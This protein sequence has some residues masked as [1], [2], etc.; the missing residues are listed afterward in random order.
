MRARPPLSA[1]LQ[2]PVLQS[3]RRAATLLTASA[4]VPCTAAAQTARQPIAFAHHTTWGEAAGLPLSGVIKLA[5]TPDGYLWLGSTAGLLR[6][7]GMRFSVLDGRSVAALSSAVPGQTWPLLVDREGVLWISRPD[8]GIVQYRAGVFRVALDPDT[9][10]QRVFRMAQDGRGGL[11]LAGGGSLYTWADGHLARPRLPAAVPDTGILGVVPDTGSG[12]W[13]GTR[14][15]GLW[16]V[17]GEQARYYPTPAQTRDPGVRPLLQSRDGA[18]WVWGDRLQVLHRERWSRLTLA[19]HEGIPSPSV[20]EAADGSIWIATRGFGVLRWRAGQLEQFTEEDGLSD[21][22]VEE[23]LVD[24]EGNT[25]MTTDAGL[26]RLRPAA[27]ATLNRRHGLPFASPLLIYN[28]ADG[29]IWAMANGDGKVYRLDGGIIR[30]QAGSIASQEPRLPADEP[31]I[32][33]APARDGGVWL[34]GRNSDRLLRYRNGIVTRLEW[35]PALLGQSPRRALEDRAGNLWVSLFPHG[36]GRVRDGRFEPVSLPGAPENVRVT[37]IVESARG[38]VWIS[39]AEHALVYELD[40]DREI[41][42]LDGSHGLPGPV[43]HLAVEGD[44]LWAVTGDGSLVRLSGGR[45]T[46]VMVEALKGTLRAESVVLLPHRG[47]LWV[48]SAAGVATVPLHALHLGADEG[49]SAITPRFFTSF[50]GLTSGKVTGHNQHPAFVASDGRLWFSTPGGLAVVDPM[51]IGTNRVPPQVHIEDVSASG[52]LFSPAPDLAITPN[53]DRVVIR[54][55]ATSLRMPERVRIEYQLEGADQSWVNSGVARSAT[56]TQLRPG[57]YR[58]RVR[59][60]NEDGVPSVQEATLGFRVLPRWYQT[61]WFGTLLFLAV[62]A[63]GAALVHATQRARA[64][65]TAERMRARFEATL[66]ERTRLARELHDTLLQGFTGIT[67]QLQ[68]VHHAV[69]GVSKDAAGALSR[70]LALADITLRD[71]RQ[72]VWDMRAPELD[73]QDLADAL[74]GAA[75]G[76]LVGSAIDLRFEVSG[77]RRRLAL[78]VETAVLRI[79]REAVVNA[80][81]HA[82]PRTVDIALAFEPRSVRLSVSDDGHGLALE[83]AATAVNGGHWG[84]HGMRERATR[85]G[86]TLAIAGLPGRGTVVSLEL[87]VDLEG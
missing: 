2:A 34:V 17:S 62:A 56:Y 82:D 46:P 64:R 84:I 18:L 75:R 7:D 26:D 76:A 61:W 83:S 39:V 33:L 78:D 40:G 27:F 42:R 69:E 8:G 15:Q 32:P 53:P 36:F 48:A 1:R 30:G 57:R 3:C 6:F 16:H 22:V 13:I 21:A 51:Q 81:K 54:Y 29:A 47:N 12:V 73:E 25:W 43:S 85:A 44:T 37:S 66:V 28:D 9:N 63:A 45:A 11:W 4:L 38:Q 58:F 49:R 19:G 50:D 5:R 87:P 70:V 71:A 41:R 80:I 60:W 31:H 55:A 86:G 20:A 59:A 67:L 68:A 14:N 24:P 10:Y 35:N 52:Q 65:R 79:G 77:E 23:L 74:E 72:M